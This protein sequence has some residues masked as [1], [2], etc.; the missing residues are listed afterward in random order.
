MKSRPLVLLVASCLALA[1]SAWAQPSG[2][3]GD[4]K[5]PAPRSA[6]DTALDGFAK[7]INDRAAKP[8]QARF[9]K[10][11][12]TGVAFII[13]NPT[14]A[15]VNDVINEVASFGETMRDKATALMKPVY[16]SQLKYEL[17]N[18]RYKEGLS[19]DAKAAVAALD[20]GLADYEARQVLSKA[21]VENLREKI[22]A[23]GKQPAAGRFLKAREQ[24]YFEVLTYG[25]S[26]AAGEAHLKTL[27]THADKGV[28]DWAKDEIKLVE[29]KK[30]PYELK[31]TGVDGKPCDFAQL[32]GKVVALVFWSS[33]NQGSTRE[34]LSL[35]ETYN[36]YKKKGFEIV[37]VSYDK[38]EDREKVVKFAKD[39]KLAWPVYFDGTEMNNEFGQKLNVKRLPMIAMF[40]KKGILVSNTVRANRVGAEAARLLGVK[41]EAPPPKEVASDEGMGGGKG[42]SRR[43]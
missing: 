16:V 13:E 42:G 41:E 24:S 10:I 33:A 6:A 43:R 30:Q 34:L 19:D 5:A 36:L 22:D 17:V 18:L 11:I 25:V 4:K 8:D 26:P 28:A 40:D 1:V 27:F 29:I 37:T 12:S 32:R 31:F 23:L 38:N 39:N 20:A 3:S 21:N 2:K 9:Q 15:R 7:I 14:H 35:Q